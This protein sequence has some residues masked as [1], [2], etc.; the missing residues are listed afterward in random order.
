MK[1]D[2]KIEIM[3]VN[4]RFE[5]G[6]VFNFGKVIDKVGTY[7]K[8]LINKF[9][10]YFDEFINKNEDFFDKMY[11]FEC[12]I[13]DKID[14]VL[15]KSI[16]CVGKVSDFVSK[17]IN[18]SKRESKSLYK[19]QPMDNSVNLI[20]DGVIELKEFKLEDYDTDEYKVV[21]RGR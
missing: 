6:I 19:L 1:D 14:F 7:K 20:D 8:V 17:E 5:S 9:E 3:D 4:G 21:H 13:D 2:K 18:V 16:D 15:D 12:M 10:Y 11:D